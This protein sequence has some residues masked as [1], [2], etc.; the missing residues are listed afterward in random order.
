MADQEIQRETEERADAPANQ[1]RAAEG[2]LTLV[3][4][5]CGNEKYVDSPAAPPVSLCERCGGTVFR[6]FFTPTEPDD[7]IISQLEATA[8]SVAFDEESP[9]TS[10]DEVQDLNNP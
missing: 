10:P 7:A 3:C 1:S 4:L 6:S 9:G 2:L 8:R 5:T